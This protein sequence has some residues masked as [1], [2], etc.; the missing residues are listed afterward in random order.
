MFWWKS[1]NEDNSSLD[2]AF[3]GV[4]QRMLGRVS[5]LAGETLKVEAAGWEFGV[6]N[7]IFLPAQAVWYQAPFRSVPK[8]LTHLP[9]CVWLREAKVWAVRTNRSPTEPIA[10]SSA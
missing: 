2:V 7:L 10:I 8:E 6:W 9:I 5:L 3:E 1:L 4:L